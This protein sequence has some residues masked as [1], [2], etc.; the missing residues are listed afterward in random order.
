MS[1]AQAVLKCALVARTGTVHG[2]PC[3]NGVLA[4]IALHRNSAAA[5]QLAIAMSQI[6]PPCANI[7]LP[8][9][10]VDEAAVA[11]A[12]VLDVLALV[13]VTIGPCIGAAPIFDVVLDALSD[14]PI[15]IPEAAT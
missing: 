4:P 11:L 9:L 7:L 15:T 12:P 6:C 1:V 2:C 13:D 8:C 10:A 5:E 14:V 3:N